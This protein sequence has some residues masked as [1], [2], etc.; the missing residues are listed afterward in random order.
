MAEPEPPSAIYAS[1]WPRAIDTAAPLCLRLGVEARIDARLEEL[2]IDAEWLKASGSGP[3]HRPDLQVWE[4]G[5]RARD[6][7]E[8]LAEFSSRVSE[9]CEEL[10]RR[11][12]RERVVLFTHSGT[13]DAAVRWAMG[14][15]PDHH[16]QS[17]MP[18]LTASITELVYWPHGRVRRGAPR[19]ATLRRIGDVTHLGD[20]ASEY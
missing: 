15:S 17:D 14:I 11:H 6:R 9:V 18:I 4:P 12:L 7:G 5:H 3:E 2:E 13:I 1:P 19:Y 10:V 20:L 8:T 16:W